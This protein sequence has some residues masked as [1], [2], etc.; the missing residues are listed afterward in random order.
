MRL[1]S[2][3]FAVSILLAPQFASVAFADGRENPFTPPTSA[4]QE[5]A[6]QDERIRRVL[7][8]SSSDIEAKVMQSVSSSIAA[9]EIRMKRRLD[10]V[11]VQKPAENALP[12]PG[13]DAP[14]NG[15]GSGTVASPKG[16]DGKKDADD[17]NT[18]KFISCVN[19]KALYRDKDN[20]LFQ[21]SGAGPNGVDPCSR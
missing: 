21:I 17:K 12:V 14:K 10:E 4:E 7:I 3:L 20:T 8:E 5:Q 16:K 19:G 1:G 2:L 15:S 6:R 9:A 18:A 11:A 13:K